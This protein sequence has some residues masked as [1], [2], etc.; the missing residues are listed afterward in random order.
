MSWTLRVPYRDR[1]DDLADVA[2]ASRAIADP[3]E[4][5]VAYQLAVDAAPSGAV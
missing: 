2:L 5:A 3:E 4:R 1:A